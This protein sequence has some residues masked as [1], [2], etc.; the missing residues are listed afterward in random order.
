M[1]GVLAKRTV[2]VPQLDRT[3]A[4]LTLSWA[5]LGFETRGPWAL[6]R[7]LGAEAFGLIDARALPEGPELPLMWV[8]KRPDRLEINRAAEESNP[9]SPTVLLVIEQELS[10]FFQEEVE[11]RL[12][13]ALRQGRRGTGTSSG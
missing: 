11:P 3:T 4:S 2:E 7:D 12:S 13:Q 6:A 10:R 8:Y 1:N 5:D 9:V